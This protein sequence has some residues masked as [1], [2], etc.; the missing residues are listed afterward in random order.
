MTMQSTSLPLPWRHQTGHRWSMLVG[1]SLWNSALALFECL[2]CAAH[3]RARLR[4]TQ[5]AL[6]Q[7]D[8]HILA[9]I[10]LTRGEIEFMRQGHWRFPS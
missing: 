4:R 10:G 9:D 8:Q 3:A 1:A 5:Y 6:R 7:L 2:R